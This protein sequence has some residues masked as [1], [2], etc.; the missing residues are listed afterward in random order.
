M[1]WPIVIGIIILLFI[2]DIL[3]LVKGLVKVALIV[4]AILIIL[5]TA[6]YVMGVGAFEG[7]HDVKEAQE[8]SQPV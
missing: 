6:A 1:F 4:G 8:T 7:I 5:Y 2:P 3:S